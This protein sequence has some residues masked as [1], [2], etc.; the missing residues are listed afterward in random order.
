M[1]VSGVVE[2]SQLTEVAARVRERALGRSDSLP[3][4]FD[5]L[6]AASESGRRPKEFEVAQEVY[7]RSDAFDGGQDATV[8]V[9]IHRL[10][11]KL[12]DY[13]AGEGRDEPFR[14]SLPKG[15]YRFAIDEVAP[16][17]SRITS[18]P[19]RLPVLAVVL[20]LLGAT[21]GMLAT[22]WAAP[23]AAARRSSPWAELIA[24]PGPTILVLGDYYIFGETDP[25]TGVKR[26]VREYAINSQE[27][28]DAWMME[29]PDAMGRYQDLGLRYLPVGAAFALQRLSPLLEAPRGDRRPRVVMASDLTADM[30][31]ANNIVY[32]GYLSGLGDLRELVFSRS[33]FKVGAS[34][35]QLAEVET[36]KRYV[37]SDE[38]DPTSRGRGRDYGY[39]ASFRGPEGRQ[40]VILAGARDAALKQVAEIAASPKA[41]KEL[42]RVAGRGEPFEAL[43]EVETLGRSSLS[44]RLVRA[45]PRP[46]AASKTPPVFPRG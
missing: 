33:N 37:S 3:R 17:E 26:L 21:V 42:A 9:A 44:S 39:F 11:R 12:A 19:W 22:T 27:E 29:D 13:Y 20:I 31:K 35:D 1:K 18:I 8:R 45:T 2:A 40:V 34:W 41:L 43:Y 30:L 24:A 25:N 23:G 36:G 28:L 46:K 38:L 32:V 7:G 5:Y 14:L 16:S 6:L 4:L 15:E 10:R